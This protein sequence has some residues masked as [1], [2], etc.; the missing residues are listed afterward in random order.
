M[1]TNYNIDDH[2][3]NAM[4]NFEIQPRIT[5]FDAVMKKLEKKRR[6]R[7]FMLFFFGACVGLL[8]FLVILNV[9]SRKVLTRD[10]E[11]HLPAKKIIVSKKEITEKQK[12]LKKPATNEHV[13]S[14][15][16]NN[17]TKQ[18]K[19]DIAANSQKKPVRKNNP[20]PVAVTPL[21]NVMTVQS[22]Q[23]LNSQA[24][25]DKNG[26]LVSDSLNS[27]ETPFVFLDQKLL[28]LPQVDSVYELTFPA[29]ITFPI[30]FAQKPDSLPKNKKRFK[31]MIGLNVNPQLSSYQFSENKHRDA[32]YDNNTTGGTFSKLYIENRKKQ[33]SFKL[34]YAF[35]IKFGC[36]VDDKW[37]LWLAAGIQRYTY[38][39]R[40]YALALKLSN[41]LVGPS[42]INFNAAPPSSYY[43]NGFKSS[44]TYVSY[45]LDFNKIIK[46]NPFLKLKFGLGLKANNLLMANYIYVKSPDVYYS[47]NYTGRDYLS[48]WMYTT[49]LNLGVIKDLSKRLQFRLSPG[50]FY[51][52]SSMFS[53]N[54]V[55]KQKS[56]GLEVECLL[57]LK[58]F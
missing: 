53:K 11:K 10:S 40:L 3:Q 55:I 9:P 2:L 7:F 46:P 6:R 32:I 38:S 12:I 42:G 31:F 44:F 16:K 51:S 25:T 41:T 13:A 37:E 43:E 36:S 18:D 54:Y 8:G 23:S 28:S 20:I 19:S 34:N 29:A 21:K 26:S 4:D 5:S 15:Q 50:V 48:L 49:N 17:K 22:F 52:P 24:Q 47:N 45:C 35:G 58:L 57:V 30:E 27:K 1:N 33:N 14:F 56:F 39:E